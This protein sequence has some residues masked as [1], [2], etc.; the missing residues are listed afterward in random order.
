MLWFEVAPV[1]DR[2]GGAATAGDVDGL[3][4]GVVAPGASIVL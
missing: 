1:V 4:A 2:G 3:A